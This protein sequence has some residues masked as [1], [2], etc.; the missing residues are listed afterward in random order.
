MAGPNGQAADF[1]QRFPANKLTTTI[2]KALVT[3]FEDS[4]L[5]NTYSMRYQAS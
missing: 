2:N 5:T 4:R 3:R 1:R